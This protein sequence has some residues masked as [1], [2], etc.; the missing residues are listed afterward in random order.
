MEKHL[1][2]DVFILLICVLY[3]MGV[4]DHILVVK[5]WKEYRDAVP[6]RVNMTFPAE[7]QDDTWMSV[8]I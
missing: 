4:F 7:L 1:S 6:E 8:E 5:N 2:I 3:L